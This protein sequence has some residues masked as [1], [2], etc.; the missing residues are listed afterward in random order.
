[1][2]NRRQ[3]LER[4]CDRLMTECD[5]AFGKDLAPLSRELRQTIAELDGLPDVNAKAPTDEIAKRRNERRRKAA[6]E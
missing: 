4:L 3:T 1:M 6:G 5:K 2:L